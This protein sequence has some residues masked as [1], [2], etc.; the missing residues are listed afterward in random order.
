MKN[1]FVHWISICVLEAVIKGINT[2][3][4]RNIKHKK[5]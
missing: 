5:E 2:F 3:F 4:A 1:K